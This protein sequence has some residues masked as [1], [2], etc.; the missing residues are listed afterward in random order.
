MFHGNIGMVY[1]DEKNPTKITNCKYGSQ[2]IKQNCNYY[3][4]PIKFIGSKDTRNYIASSFLYVGGA[5]TGKPHIEP[6]NGQCYK[7]DGQCY[8]PD[9][10]CY[11]PDGQCY[12]PDGQ[13][14]KPNGLERTERSGNSDKITLT[15]SINGQSFHKAHSDTKTKNRRF[16]SRANLE[17]DILALNEEEISRFHDQMMHDLLCSLLLAKAYA[18]K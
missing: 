5:F 1:C 11:K 10:Q 17:S 9:G 4:D 7:P 15:S 8:K 16:G 6:M 14:Y 3:H 2:C 18:R 13:C 12:K